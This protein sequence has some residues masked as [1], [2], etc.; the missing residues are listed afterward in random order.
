MATATATSTDFILSTRS[1]AQTA[2]QSGTCWRAMA[3]ALMMKSL[4]E[5]FTPRA[6]SSLL[7]CER[8][9]SSASSRISRRR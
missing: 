2:L 5:S 7:S 9:A 8:K 3:E 6:S 1:P 4:T